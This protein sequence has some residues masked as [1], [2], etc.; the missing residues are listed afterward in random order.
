MRDERRSDWPIVV[1]GCHRSGTSLIRRVLDSHTRIHCGPEVKFFADLY[2]D[3][4]PDPWQMLRFIPTAS[5][6]LADDDLLEVLGGAF[7]QIHSRAAR[8]AGKPRWA[9]KTP[10]N[11]LYCPQ[12]QRLL[13]DQWLLVHVL[14]NP[15]DTIA[16]I[17]EIR[18]VDVPAAIPGQIAHYRAYT[19]AGLRFGA[20]QPARYV[21]VVYEQLVTQPRDTLARLMISLG[22]TLEPQQL[23]FNDHPHQPGVEDPKVIPTTRVHSD[24]LHRW[25]EALS[26][27]EARMIWEGTADLWASVDPE[28][29]FVSAPIGIRG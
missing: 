29:Q 25:G 28:G 7:V 22:E 4:V 10:E 19:E 11:V 3:K 24:S 18:F 15:L 23:S 17:G 27:E 1:G 9:D 12:W 5:T 14:R 6:L 8:A 21:P 16:S 20:E 2:G 13:H 26:S